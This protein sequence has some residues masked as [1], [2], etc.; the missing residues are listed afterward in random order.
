MSYI[1]FP[2]IS[3]ELFSIELFGVTFALRWYAL[4][5]IAGLLIGWRLVLRMIR[6]ERLWSFG[7]PMTEDQLERLLTWVIL[8]VILGGRLGFV[9]F[10]QPAH[11]L[12]HPLD[13]LKVWEGGMS[14]H[15]G[16]LGVMT[17]LV[18]FCLKERISILPVADLL[19]AATP[20]GLFLGRIANFI[21]AELWGRPTTLPWGV[22]FPG[23]AA[24]SCPG[25]EGICARHPSQ[26]YE[27]GLEGILLFTVLS[28]LV[29]RRGWLHW[30][31]SVSGMFLAGYGATR[32]LV[33]FVRQPD[34]QFVSAGNPLGLAWQISGYGLTMGQILS[35]PMILLGLYLILRSRRTA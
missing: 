3:P 31:G 32:F 21:N 18:A 16:F 28:L 27:A 1:P 35:L 33:E 34:A 7:P 25:I 19:A 17:A 29:W 26:I 22:A 13:I 15:G 20:P 8:G 14:F 24:Q 2:D 10:Y 9:L 4:A 5:Y 30:P 11:Y 23:E 6:A 12:A